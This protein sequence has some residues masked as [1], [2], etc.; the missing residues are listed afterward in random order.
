ML[1]IVVCK[2]VL[3]LFGAFS[4]RASEV[5]VLANEYIILKGNRI[6]TG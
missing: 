2:L 1:E 6:L 3:V 5:C 4:K